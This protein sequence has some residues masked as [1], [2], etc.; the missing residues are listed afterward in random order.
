MAGFPGTAGIDTGRFGDKERRLINKMKF[1]P[2]FDKKVN[3][4]KV[5]LPVIK[6][7]IAER[8]LELLGFEDD[9]LVQFVFNL[10][11]NAK[12]QRSSPDPKQIQIQITGF[13]ER[14]AKTFTEELWTHLV[15]ASRNPGGIPTSMLEETKKKLARRNKSGSS[16]RRKEEED[17][18]EEDAERNLQEAREK[19]LEQSKN[20]EKKCE[21]SAQVKEMLENIKK[22]QREQ[23]K[24]KQQKKTI[25]RSLADCFS[26]S[27]V[28]MA[29]KQE[30]QERRIELKRIRAIEERL[31]AE[32]NAEMKRKREWEEEEAAMVEEQTKKQSIS[33]EKPTRPAVKQRSRSRSRKRRSRSRS[34]KRRR[35]PSR[36]P[37]QR[38]PTPST[39]PSPPR[40]WLAKKK[41]R[42]K[43]SSRRRRSPSSSS[44][45]SS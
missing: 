24:L 37:M 20:V 4:E 41:K 10:L 17:R 9:I 36:S 32:R 35:S 33:P 42:S 3:M 5:A 29:K 7:W 23:D 13:L 12:K 45:S 34:R 26:K 2:E 6:R 11:E 18:D 43:K 19:A 1:P 14:D 27:I 16:R 22:K 28:A 25:P 8:I 40:E 44:D 39:S 21:Q 31:E 38:D 30:E 15:S